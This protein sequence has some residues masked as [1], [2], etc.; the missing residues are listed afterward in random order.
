MSNIDKIKIADEHT[1]AP[2]KAVKGSEGEPE[3]WIVVADGEKQYH[4]ATIENGQPGDCLETE[5]ATARVIA[6][7][8]EL[9]KAVEELLIASEWADETGYVVD[10]GFLDVDAIKAKAVAAI[11][12]ARGQN[13]P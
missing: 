1:P 5:G 11:A 13:H 6:A 12:K 3:R 7:A 9:L 2:W 8:P 4:I 10:V